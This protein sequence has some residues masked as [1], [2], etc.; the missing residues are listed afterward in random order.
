MILRKTVCICKELN[1]GLQEDDV[2]ATDFLQN[3][4]WSIGKD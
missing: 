2:M 1:V 3:F 4:K